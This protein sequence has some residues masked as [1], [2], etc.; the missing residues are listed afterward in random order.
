[1]KIIDED[2]RF[3]ELKNFKIVSRNSDD[4]WNMNLI[5]TV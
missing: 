5:E 1:M 3:D 4:E 2:E